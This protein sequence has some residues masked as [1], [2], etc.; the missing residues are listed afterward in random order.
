MSEQLDLT[1]LPITPYNNT[2]GH[3]GSDTSRERAEREDSNGTTSYRQ[4]ETLS[5]LHSRGTLGVT[6]KELGERYN[7]HHGQASGVLS[8]LHKEGW[9]V[10]L[11]ERRNKCAVYVAPQYSIG[12]ELSERKIKSCPNCGWHK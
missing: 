12:R 9:I 11:K 5:M 10:R 3:S 6:W 2:S 1:Q 4:R 8:V 7:W